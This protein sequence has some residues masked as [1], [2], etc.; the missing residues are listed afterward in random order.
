MTI[1]GYNA[2][3]GAGL[4]L[5]IEGMASSMDEKAHRVGIIKAL[6]DE[7][8]ELEEMIRI[9]EGKGPIQQVFVGLNIFAKQL[10][11][12]VKKIALQNP[13]QSISDIMEDLGPKFVSTIKFAEEYRDTL[14]EPSLI[15]DNHI[16]IRIV[17]NWVNANA[18]DILNGSAEFQ[19]S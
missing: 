10:F 17:A 4:N 1:C 18:D 3:I 12:E 9:M 5:L 7:L 19:D 8:F 6:D 11:L 13:H 16:P 14:N 2:K 15:T